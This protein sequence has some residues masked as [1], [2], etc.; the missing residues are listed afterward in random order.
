MGRKEKKDGKKK[1]SWFKL[2]FSLFFLVVTILFTLFTVSFI[3]VYKDGWEWAQK[4]PGV[5][6][7]DNWLTGY[8]ANL[9]EHDKII[10][11]AGIYSFLIGLDVF[12]V[13]TTLFYPIKKIPILG[14]FLRWITGIIPGLAIIAT[15][16][17]AVLLWLV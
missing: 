7:L 10:K 11:Q 9:T 2:I 12:L 1:F 3:G 15:I 14:K 4:I 6:A 17:G 5:S 8:I 13:Y 16:I